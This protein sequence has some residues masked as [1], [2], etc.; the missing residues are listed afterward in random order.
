[1]DSPKISFENI[2]FETLVI[3]E[4]NYNKNKKEVIQQ[5]IDFINK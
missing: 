1:M 4:Y 3:W 2:G 5:C